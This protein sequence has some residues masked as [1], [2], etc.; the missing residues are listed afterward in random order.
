MSS[1]KSN[2]SS[3]KQGDDGSGDHN[4]TPTT[5]HTS[6]TTASHNSSEPHHA[7]EVHSSNDTTPSH[8]SGQQS[9][10]VKGAGG[11]TVSGSVN[12]KLG[13]TGN[14]AG[15]SGKSGKDE[16]D[17]AKVDS[18]KSSGTATVQSGSGQRVPHQSTDPHVTSKS[19]SYG[20][21]GDNKQSGASKAAAASAT[22]SSRPLGSGAQAMG[23]DGKMAPGDRLKREN[24]VPGSKEAKGS[25]GGV[26]AH[27]ASATT[28]KQHSPSQ[29]QSKL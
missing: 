14:N 26:G 5:K 17:E 12:T 29:V 10:P 7:K 9:K 16:D 24:I 19:P 22:T 15:M 25:L 18:G 3:S 28:G 20:A 21:S 2:S 4:S 8:S 11:P 1:S 27:A 13:K 23:K 6:S